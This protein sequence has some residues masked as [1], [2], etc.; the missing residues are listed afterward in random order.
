M[1]KLEEKLTEE[2]K[3]KQVSQFDLAAYLGVS[4]QAISRWET[5]AGKPSMDNLRALSQLYGV[6]LDYLVDADT[7]SRHPDPLAP[8]APMPWVPRITEEPKHS[9]E[10]QPDKRKLNKKWIIVLACL[11]AAGIIWMV[12]S[13]AQSKKETISIEEMPVEKAEDGYL[14]GPT[15]SVGW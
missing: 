11:C 2:R 14:P 9:P 6:P 3:K 5:G 10:S 12:S 8:A 1:M 7:P 13:Y 15:F 4:R